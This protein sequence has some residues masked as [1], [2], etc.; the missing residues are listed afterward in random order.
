MAG[1]SFK[2]NLEVLNL[3]DIL[4]SL[5]MNRHSGTLIVNDGKREKK[6]FFAEG[7]IT[8]LSTS[9]RQRIGDLLI[10]SGKITEE[11]LDLALKLQKQSRNKKLGEIL[12]EEGFCEQEDIGR[13][14]RMQVE[15]ELYDLFLW[16]KA[17]FE[18]LADQMPEDMVAESPNLTRL[19]I[20]TNSLIMEALRR[21]DEWTLIQNLVPSTKEVFAIADRDAFLDADV[22]ER[23]KNEPELI[24]GKT[25]VEG[26]AER[27]YVSEFELCQHLAELV[28]CGAIRALS[29]E[30]LA[31]R[32]EA[33]YALN[34][35]AGSAALYGRLAEYFPD[36][37]KIMVPLADSMRRSGADRQALALYEELASRLET[38]GGD[39]DRLRQC[40]EA[41]TQLD[42][43]RLDL[44]RKLENL[45]LE[46]ASS[47]GAR[48][49]VVPLL[50]ALALAAGGGAVFAFRER[51]FGK[52]NADGPSKN[53][54]LVL[55]EAIRA[56]KA[57]DYRTMHERMRELLEHHKGTKEFA[58]VELP[59]LVETIPP[60][61]DVYVNGVYQGLT[62][63]DSPRLV[64][65]YVPATKV[66]VEVFA[67]EGKRKGEAPLDT[68]VLPADSY[69][70][71]R[72]VL[73]SKPAGSFIGDGWLEAGVVAAKDPPVLLAP[74]R[75][76]L[77]RVLRASERGL[78]ADPAFDKQVRLGENGD[79]LTPPVLL[80]DA[81]LVGTTDRGVLSISLRDGTLGDAPRALYPATFRVVGAPVALDG[82]AV[83]GGRVAFVTVAGEVLAY[84]LAGG[85]PV[86]R[87]EIQG[88]VR[89]PPLHLPA[90]ADL[91]HRLVVTGA[92]HH[93][94]AF[95][96]TDGS[97]L[98]DYASAHP[99]AGDL[100]AVGKEV[101]VPLEEGGVLALDA[102]SG[103]ARRT[104]FAEFAPPPRALLP[105][106]D[107]EFLFTASSDGRVRA[108]RGGKEAVWEFRRPA[109][110]VPRLALLDAR[111][112]VVAADGP[113]V[114]VL[115]ADR[116]QIVWQARFPEG[117]SSRT[118]SPI[119]V[120][121]DGFLVGTNKRFLH[122]FVVPSR[123]P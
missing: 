95:S 101:L 93:V 5:A 3:S 96:L 20:N 71:A 77:L 123:A 69:Q 100:V 116:G 57:G 48:G 28:K 59:V 24:D 118:I 107:G 34:D 110:H 12:V 106:L 18:F 61:Y 25:N 55:E 113:E 29:Q 26:L 81:L 30:E 27:L 92:D 98:W 111:H 11:D 50:V 53:A 99:V 82:E 102:A 13:L 35:F 86:W 119:S 87:A 122:R 115:L 17:E 60:G 47:Q 44:A 68:R 49:V 41:I 31:E 84:A 70:E 36:E 42:P 40:Y 79:P 103:E 38:D 74:S 83:E 51:L 76:G 88:V 21:L 62:E 8:L 16:R 80:G 37:P 105:S 54:A 75:S 1:K 121:E 91:P 85:D 97:L 63:V 58:K 2:G 43:T 56:E 23:L 78:T 4:Q 65:K 10:A 117:G 46:A 94:S 19:N 109:E 45:E 89:R 72:F 108:F 7:E 112:L 32:A 120:V 39:P 90:T 114:Y 9:R 14:L 67:P 6:I 15:D 73:Y 52:R 22:P 64:C 104:L 33:A 66:K